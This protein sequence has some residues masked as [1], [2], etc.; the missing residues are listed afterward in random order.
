[1]SIIEDF[2]EI[3]VPPEMS[4]SGKACAPEP[5]RTQHSNLGRSS[6][7]KPSFFGAFLLSYISI[8]RPE[9]SP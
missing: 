2:Q 3:S 9:M 8:T 1:V 7:K 6:C 4:N 5:D